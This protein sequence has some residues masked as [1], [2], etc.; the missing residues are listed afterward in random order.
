MKQG[1]TQYTPRAN[2]EKTS[3]TSILKPT[4]DGFVPA[5]ERI[6][7]FEGPDPPNP[8]MQIPEGEVDVYGIVAGRRRMSEDDE[9]QIRSTEIR[10]RLEAHQVSRALQA[11]NTSLESDISPGKGWEV[12]DEPSGYCD[13]TYN[14]IC[15]RDTD[16]MCVLQGRQAS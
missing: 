9:F 8:C 7:A 1:A 4:V 14:T 15:G 5:N 3:I 12:F 11:Q 10:H 2:P 13:G 16:Y 6:E